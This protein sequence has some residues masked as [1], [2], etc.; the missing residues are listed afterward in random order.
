MTQ[1]VAELTHVQSLYVGR[2]QS[3]WP[4][5]A[6]SAINK[7]LVEGP[8]KLAEKGFYGDEQADPRHHG[9]PDKAVHHY[10]ADHYTYWREQL[11]SNPRFQ[12]GGFGENISAFGLTEQRVCIGDVFTLGDALVQISQGRQPC[13]KL[14]AHTGIPDLSHRFMSTALTGWYYRVITPGTVAIGDE[15][16]LLKRPN[17]G[18]TVKKVTEARFNPR[19]DNALA[20]DLATLPYLSLGWRE[21]FQKASDAQ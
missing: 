18:W 11:G 9:G 4:N 5:K 16:K 1:I 14:N 20:R 10:A 2:V 8:I 3:P 7:R 13:W 6:P 19:R 12:P 21:V 15:L 17:P